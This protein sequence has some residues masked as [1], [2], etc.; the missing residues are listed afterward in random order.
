M[1]KNAIPND[2]ENGNTINIF[3]NSQAKTNST[4]RNFSTVTWPGRY[5]LSSSVWKSAK[6][7]KNK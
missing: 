6:S 3:K 5:G 1:N 4:Q 2:I 7:N